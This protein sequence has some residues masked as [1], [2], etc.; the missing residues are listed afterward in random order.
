MD[1]KRVT[2]FTGLIVLFLSGFSTM[3][4]AGDINMTSGN[5]Y[6]AKLESVSDT[7]H[8]AGLTV[9]NNAQ[10]LSESS[11]PFMSLTINSPI[12]AEVSFPGEN[13]KD[14]VHYYAAMIPSSFDA[15]NLENISNSDLAEDGLFNST[16]YPTFH[17]NYDSRN[18]NP[19]IT[20]S[21]NQTNITIAGVN[22]TAFVVTLPTNIPYYVLKY[23]DGG[24]KYPL[25]I[26]PFDDHICYNSTDCVGQF[27]LPV[28][29]DAYNFYILTKYPS[30]EYTIYIDG[31]Q[32]NTFSQTALAYNLTIFVNNTYTH[33]P[34]VNKS[35]VVSE[36]MG[37]NLFIP[38]E[39]TGFVSYAYSVGRTDD[40][41][42]ETFIVAPTVYPS[43]S[44]YSMKIG[45]LQ[46]N[47]L[48]STEELYITSKDSLVTQSKPLSPTTLFDD[49]KAS[50]NAMNQ[51]SNYLFR[52]SSQMLQA[53]KFYIAYETTNNSFTTYNYLNSS[54][55]LVLKS[56]APNVLTV[57]VTTNG[58]QQSAYQ[59]RVKETAGYLI[60]N[61]RIGTTPISE[62]TRYHYQTINVSNEFIIT[63]TSLGVVSSNVTF[64]ILDSGNNLLNTYVADIDSNL[65]IQTGGVFYNNDLLKTIANAMNQI[66]NSLYYSLNN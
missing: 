59:V 50:V 66:L 12:M 61:P 18:D 39:L 52:W 4:F 60:M 51:I 53:K 62:K 47:A 20:F 65:N 37:Q 24:V 23:D 54:S 17:P 28:S 31:V 56:G 8:W 5:S 10:D 25:F 6:Y 49:A 40:S 7:S 32:T 3:V 22:Y 34:A 11:S 63:P 14:G 16:I 1:L 44:S 45:V 36:E 43:D 57:Y 13:L 21:S 30:Y 55:T 26:V 46:G 9:V 2:F 41:G 19:N 27:L 35:I 64:E 38:Y 15:N 42:M 48:S 58:V 33:Q 29:D